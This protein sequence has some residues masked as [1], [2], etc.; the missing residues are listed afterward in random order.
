MISQLDVELSEKKELE[1]VQDLVI[2]YLIN[3]P[4]DIIETS[5]LLPLATFRQAEK[6]IVYSSLVSMAKDEIPIDLTQLTIYLDSRDLLGKA[7]GLMG[8]TMLA[9]GSVINPSPSKKSFDISVKYLT[10]IDKRSKLA[11]ALPKLQRDLLDLSKSFDAVTAKSI[12][13]LEQFLDNDR[14]D[15]AGL[16]VIGSSIN[17]T[18]ETIL[19]E[20]DDQEAGISP[21][22]ISTGFADLDAHMGGWHRGDFVVIGATPGMGK[23]AFAVSTCLEIA[24]SGHPV[25]FFSLEMTTAQMQTRCLSMTSRV[26]SGKI[27]DRKLTQEEKE[28]LITASAKLSDLNYWGTDKFTS[29]IDFVV[30]ESRKLAAKHGQI[31]A[32][33]IDYIQLLVQDAA[34]SINEI[35]NIT[36]RLKSLAIELNC[37]IFGLSQLNR[38]V[39]SRNDKRPVK[40]DLRSC[41]SIEQDSDIVLMLYRD[42]TVNP[43]TMDKGIAEVGI[44]KFR[45]GQE[46]VIKL[47]FDGSTTQFYNLAKNYAGF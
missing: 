46:G 43:N 18:L 34:N 38:S 7:G 22:A 15:S 24:K 4:D 6:Y 11:N 12:T 25:A 36:R 39:A 10:D 16:S 2:A 45:N 31:G 14:P 17:D 30:N 47:G 23:S 5:Q 19:K 27:R 9:E 37:T 20:C 1:D 40:S 28:R 13:A 42:E 8:V 41:G 44:V 32:I 3:N 33:A 21:I 35:S 26:D 29:S